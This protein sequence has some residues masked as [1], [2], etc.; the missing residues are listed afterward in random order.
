MAAFTSPADR[1]HPQRV[2]FGSGVPSGA[3]RPA[4]AS[5]PEPR[6]KAR[7]RNR[8]IHS[9]LECRRRKMKCDR[10]VRIPGAPGSELTN[11]PDR[12]PVRTAVHRC[13]DASMFLL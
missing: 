6:E 2:S 8:V 13:C 12:I 5:G 11:R 7:R 4:A 3:D 1:A 10:K 9:C